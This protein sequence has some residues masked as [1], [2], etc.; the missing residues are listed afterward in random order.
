MWTSRCIT[1]LNL[2]FTIIASALVVFAGHP[3]IPGHG[4]IITTHF[5]SLLRDICS[6]KCRK[7]PDVCMAQF[8]VLIGILLKDGNKRINR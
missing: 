7:S 8:S 4:E 1:G 2:I 5:T 6:S 3:A